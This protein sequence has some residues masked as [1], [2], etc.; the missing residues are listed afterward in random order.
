L[1]LR[2]SAVRRACKAVAVFLISLSALLLP[3]A[4]QNSAPASAVWFAD[5]KDL[6]RIDLGTNQVGLTVALDH[7]AQALAIDPVD[8]I[9]WALVQKQLLKF[10]ADG[11]S[12]LRI[13]LK[14]Q[15]KKLD[16]PRSLV[17]NPYDATL[18][19]AGEKVLLHLD[20][21]GKLLQ[22]WEA[23]DEIQSMGLDVDESLWLLTHRQLRHLSPQGAVL[24]GLDLKSYIKE[25]EHLAVDSLGG[26]L[27]VAG[28]KEL[29]QLEL[30][31]LNQTPRSISVPGGKSAEEKEEEDDDDGDDDDKKILALTADPL[32]GTLWLV[33]KHS[34]LIY[35]RSGSLLK[36]VDLGP[37]DLGGM[38]TLAFEPVSASLWLGGKKAVERF[39]SNGDFVAHV[40]V[41]KEAEAL[42]VTPFRLLPTLSLL[43]PL[44]GSLTNHPRPPIRLGLGVSCN[45]IPCILPDAYTQAL[46]LDVDLNGQAVGPLFSRPTGSEALYIAPSRLPEGLNVLDAQATDLFGHSSNR[47]TGRFTIDTIPP[48]FLSLS[49]A[50]NSNFTT[51]AVMIQGALDDP[52]AN[53]TLLDAAGQVVSMASSANFSFAVNLSPGLNVF[54]L[55]A[56]DPTGNETTTV[57]HLTYVAVTVTLVNPL[58]NASLTST[59]LD[60]NGNFQGPPNTG[61]TVNGVVA[62][63]Y[64]DQFY[65][66]LDL[67]PGVNTLTIIAT[68]PDG[69]TVT[70]T[71]T[72]TVTASAPNPVQVTVSPQG[73]VAPLAVQ[74]AINNGSG[75]GIQRIEA[76]FDGDGATDL[77]T[78][79]PTVPIAYTYAS[80]GVYRASIRVTDSQG[81]VHRK[82]LVVVVNDAAQIDQ[83]FTSLWNGMNNA[84]RTG[85]VNGAAQYL[86]ESAKRKYLPVFEALKSQFPQ[87]IA[88]Y[89]P[90]R[91]VSISEDIGEYAIV[92]NFNGQNRLYLVYFLRDADGVWRVDGM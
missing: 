61:I 73:G 41:E 6:K 89:S 38:K 2:I 42:G 17:F 13:D 7:E 88:S 83:L 33:T 70:K 77:T 69:A 59:S 37:P 66:N 51:A 24:Q 87:I 71:I 9:V 8:D 15:T 68:T 85:N 44:D 82:V 84:L 78:A 29:I 57:L 46:S 26:L 90:L 62:M 65:A 80:P 72:V 14:N 1:I 32:L 58:P 16:E 49:P 5:H 40:A 74:F 30:N 86:N 23:S 47:L 19:V 63:I 56:R 21:Q 4:A 12:I 3:A 28:K 76:D 81:A 35:D 92:R 31:Q 52:T 50:D 18:W 22:E 91:R 55:I 45:A 11:Q 54:S 27:W 39:T 48:K 67:N 34:L 53:T 20:A 75:L 10:D 60:V 79:D 43:E 36:T 64:G 25:P